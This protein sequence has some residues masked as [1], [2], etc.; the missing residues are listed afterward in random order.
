MNR[1]R[2]GGEE[3]LAAACVRRARDIKN[4][5]ARDKNKEMGA[6][7]RRMGCE[8][9]VRSTEKWMCVFGVS[10]AGLAT[11]WLRMCDTHTIYN[12]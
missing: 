10:R 4:R 7:V 6:E 11:P 5:R 3:R 8:K 12:K 2:P 9:E 1:P